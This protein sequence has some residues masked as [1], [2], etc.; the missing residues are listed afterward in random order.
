M[1]VQ[2]LEYIISLNDQLSAPL[3]GIMK[4]VDDIGVRG[5]DAMT[6][7]GVG[8]AGIIATGAALH[9]ALDPALDITRA[10][11]EV[12]ALGIVGDGLDLIQDK[13]LEF[14][15][16]YGGLATEFV[17]SSYDIQSAISGLTA[18]EVA[19]FTEAS[20]LIGKATKSSATAMTSYMGTMYGIFEKD[21]VKMGKANWVNKIAG[22]T[23]YTAN[24]F[25]SSGESMSA[26]F[27]SLGADAQAAGIDIAEQM[28]ILGNL[29]ST[30]SGSEA[31]TKYKAFLRGVGNAQKEL[32]L[33]FT[34]SQGRMLGMGDILTKLKGKFGETIDV[35]EAG[36]LKKAFGSDEAVGLINLL[37][38]KVDSLKGSIEEIAA[39]D[40][41]DEVKKMAETTTD[42]YMRLNAII[43]NIKIAIGTQ[44][45][46][47]INNTMNKIAD[48]GAEFVKWLS[49]YKNIAR[50]IGY[51]V[52][53]LIGFTALTAALTVMSGVIK[54]IGIS[55]AFL[56]SPVMLVIGVVLALGIVV[57]KFRN[58]F[59]AMFDGFIQGFRNV[60]VS[61]E[62]LF[63]AFSTLWNSLK[64][65]A[66]SI[67]RIITLIFGA[68]DGMQ[69][70]SDI[71]VSM[72]QFVAG[73]LNL[74]IS[75]ISLTADNVAII[76]DIFRGVTDAIITMWQGVVN[77]WQN[78][79]P[80]QIFGALADGMTNIFS[81]IFNGIKNMFINVLN[82]IIEKANGVGGLIGIEIPTIQAATAV[83]NNG[84]VEAVN[85][86][87]PIAS[88]ANLAGSIAS[89]SALPA[90]NSEG[91]H[92]AL[93]PTAK[94]EFKAMPKGNI[95]KNLS[96]TENKYNTVN[97]GGV[98][99][100]SNNGEDVWKKM[101][102]RAELQ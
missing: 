54:A 28:A 8:V 84:S 26:A 88:A 1:A 20:N 2:G 50:W 6:K 79:D 27:T 102:E 48:M 66:T 41:L 94:A 60:G 51:V 45:L 9:G 100:N 52:G 25:K 58:Q 15:S 40:G 35:A 70:F 17:Q 29:Q 44:V 12:S 95:T 31:G 32:G 92:F 72:G 46:K 61:F 90:P 73:A 59:S 93:A 57:Y 91:Q 67:G 80:L 19:S 74:V 83:Q 96:T 42:P 4:T 82:W 75:A 36:K 18:E 53:A 10:L 77:G 85:G 97:F 98:T 14:S 101:K 43:Q 23:T 81:S 68:G 33:S 89:A 3:K 49:T 76:A 39:I 69:T 37:L 7:I 55:F 64:S 11:N 30:M 56:T 21:A 24:M 63:S 86:V 62:P 65:I 99:I 47:A 13:A 71:G 34:D 38:P 87:N 78:S 16:T 22:Q 5:R